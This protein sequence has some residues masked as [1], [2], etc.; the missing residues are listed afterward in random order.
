MR[1]MA[2]MFNFM[3]PV[4]DPSGT[5]NPKPNPNLLTHTSVPEYKD[6]GSR[7]IGP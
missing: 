5:P 3:K 6:V 7:D 4:P 1:K 2:S